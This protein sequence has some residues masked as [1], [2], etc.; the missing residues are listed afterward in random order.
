[1]VAGL[2]RMSHFFRE[3]S[4]AF[5]K[6]LEDDLPENE[7]IWCKLLGFLNS[8]L[9]RPGCYEPFIHWDPAQVASEDSAF[10]WSFMSKLD[11]LDRKRA[12]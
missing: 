8:E 2:E 11:P 4:K 12:R 7:K 1:M 3:Y 9:K 6:R 10:F 5:A